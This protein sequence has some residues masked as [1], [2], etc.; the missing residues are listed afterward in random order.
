MRIL[1]SLMFFACMT[2]LTMAESACYERLY[3][4][5]HMQKHKL[6]EVTKIKLDL[7]EDG[8]AV[9]GVIKASFRELQEFLSSDVTCSVKQKTTSCQVG[10]NGGSFGFVQTVNG[11]KLTNTSGIRFGGEDDGVAIRSEAEHKVF[12]LFKTSCKN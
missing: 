11:I 4:A 6:Q 3:D 5:A 8:D 12:F 10:K 1:S 2:S 7:I 9:S